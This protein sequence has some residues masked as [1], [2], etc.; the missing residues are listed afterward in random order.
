MFLHGFVINLL[1]HIQKKEIQVDDL[2]EGYK[3]VMTTN[4]KMYS[5]HFCPLLPHIG[6]LWLRTGVSYPV[7]KCTRLI[8]YEVN[9]WWF[10]ECQLKAARFA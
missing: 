6:K 9:T 2:G 10:R 3:V 4:K 1:K 7:T 5:N 8:Y